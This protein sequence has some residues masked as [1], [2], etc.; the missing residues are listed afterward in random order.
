GVEG[1]PRHLLLEKAEPRLSDARALAILGARAVLDVA[2]ELLELPVRGSVSSLLLVAQRKVEQRSVRRIEPLTLGVLRAGV[3][4]LSLLDEG[5]S[6]AEEGVR[7]C[8]VFFR[9]LRPRARGRG[10]DEDQGRQHFPHIGRVTS[11]RPSPQYAGVDRAFAA[12]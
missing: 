8:D 11:F 3:A 5:L 4:E 10:H 9:W 12:S 7:P 1:D 2:E 6:L